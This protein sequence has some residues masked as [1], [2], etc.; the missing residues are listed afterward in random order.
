MLLWY[1]FK[2][3]ELK[4]CAPQTSNDLPGMVNPYTTGSFMVIIIEL[5]LKLGIKGLK[6]AS[7]SSN[8]ESRPR[9][10]KNCSTVLFVKNLTLRRILSRLECTV[11]IYVRTIRKLESFKNGHFGGWLIP[12]INVQFWNV[13]R[14]NSGFFH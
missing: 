5:R 8:L 3:K 4:G 2:L 11:G 6:I 12:L 10:A 14:Q 1:L 9:F 7:R 13:S